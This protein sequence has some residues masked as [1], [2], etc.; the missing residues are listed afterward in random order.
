M[1]WTPKVSCL[2]LWGSILLYIILFWNC[3][4]IRGNCWISSWP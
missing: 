2:L 4:K 1:H 3:G